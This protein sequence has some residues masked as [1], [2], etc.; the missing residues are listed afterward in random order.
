M[1]PLF[2]WA[3]VHSGD[4]IDCWDERVPVYWFKSVA[5]VAK[6]HHTFSDSR[7]VRVKITEVRKRKQPKVRV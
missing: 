5:N 3:V 1:R 2:A 7:I 6:L 4:E